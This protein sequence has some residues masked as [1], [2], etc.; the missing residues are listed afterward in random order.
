MKG[1]ANMFSSKTVTLKLDK[2]FSD[3]DR[4]PY[5]KGT[6]PS[7]PK[8][9]RTGPSKPKSPRHGGS[10]HGG[11]K[12][13][14]SPKPHDRADSGSGSESDQSP[15]S[16]AD[17]EL[18][19]ERTEFV[20]VRP[21]IEH[22]ML[23]IIMGLGGSELGHTLWGQTELSCYDDS[24]HGIWGMSYK[25]HER[26]IVFNEKNLIRLWDIA[27]DGYNGG[28]D[29][30][31]VDWTN[32]NSVDS[33]KE[34][35]M[36]LGKNYRGQSMMVLAFAHDRNQV[37]EYGVNLYEAQFKRNW[38]SPVVFYDSYNPERRQDSG[39]EALPLDYDNLQTVDVE[40][41]RVF[42]NELY[43]G[44][45][46][47]Y[48]NLM[49]DFRTLHMTRKSAGQSSADAE[50][51]TDCLAFQGSMRVKE[52]GQL[53]QDIQ[54]SGHHGPDYVG[55]ASVRAGKGQKMAGQAPTLH[56]LI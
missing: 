46:R 34:A 21:N 30:S 45:Y 12:G 16:D 15:D 33:F 29:D 49:P 4:D 51:G 5:W 1:H 35:T 39:R 10:K 6:G 3:D 28:K 50:T 42:N 43:N 56:R 31:Y 25:Y 14:S 36:N 13:P 24:M 22:N 20:I 37:N 55:I 52:R 47:Q 41:F 38:P 32:G 44:A 26:A 9:P 23:G 2:F 18:D 40:E 7:K 11:T 54:G 48:R 8:P 27:Y 19:P 53:L 17:E